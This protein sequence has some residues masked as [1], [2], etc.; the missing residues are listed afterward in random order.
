MYCGGRSNDYSQKK[1]RFLNV[2]WIQND[3]YS[4][5]VINVMWNLE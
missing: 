3:N 1:N 5:G 4:W 2:I